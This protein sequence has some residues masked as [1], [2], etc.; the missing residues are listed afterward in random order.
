MQKENSES[1]SISTSLSCAH[2]LKEM[3][4]VLR[5]RKLSFEFPMKKCS[6]IK[7]MI[8][9]KTNVIMNTES[10]LKF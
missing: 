1:G 7:T 3:P 6:P 4:F 8:M 9:S 5:K 10:R 2:S